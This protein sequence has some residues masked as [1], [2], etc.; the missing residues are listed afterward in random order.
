MKIVSSLDPASADLYSFAFADVPFDVKRAYWI[1]NFVPDSVRG[2]HAHRILNQMMIL[3]KG[4]LDIEL[5]RGE[6]GSKKR[7]QV[8]GECVH[9]PSAT[10]RSFSSTETQTV[11]LVLADRVYE[12]EDYIRNFNDYLEW[13]KSQ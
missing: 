6:I 11:I 2:N 13:F 5:K 10:W 4:S 7:L 1:Q 12:P 9:I 8:P 3:L